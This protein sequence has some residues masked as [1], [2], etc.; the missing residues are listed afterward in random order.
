MTALAGIWNIDGR[1]DAST[2]CRRMLAAQSLYGPH[3]TRQWDDGMI[4]LG[5]NLFR[6]LPEDKHDRQPVEAA[7]G[8]FTIVADLRLDN[9]DELC[10]ALG[11]DGQAAHWL[12]DA[13]LL[14]RAWERWQT[15]TFERLLG[16]YAVAVWDAEQRALLLGR[17]PL[18]GRPLHYHRG[19]GFVAFASMPKGL[20]AL[21]R[22]PYAPDKVRIAEQ[23]ILMPEQGPR[24]FF[25]GVCRVEPGEMVR[26]T[27]DG[28]TRHPHW[29]PTPQS[30]GNWSGGDMVEAMR[31]HIDEAVRVRLRG[32][33]DR[34]GAHLSS[35]FDSNAVASTAARLLAPSGGQVVAF[36]AVPRTGYDGPVPAGRIGDEGP[37]AAT[38]AS[39]YPNMEHVLMPTAHGTPLDG[40]DRD[41]MLFDQPMLNLCNQRWWTTISAEA[42]RRGLSVMLTGQFG[43][44]TLSY[45]GLEVLPWLARHGR[46]IALTRTIHRLIKDKAISFPGA[47]RATLGPWIPD[48]LWHRLHRLRGRTSLSLD[49]YSAVNPAQIRALDLMNVAGERA[50]DTDYR[51]RSDPFETRMWVLRR[52]DVGNWQKGVLAGWHIDQR[53]PTGDRRLVEFCLSLP[54]TAWTHGGL[55][56]LAKQVLADR[57]SPA[58]LDERRGG[59]QAADWHE[60]MTAAQTQLRDDIERFDAVPAAAEALDLA[61]MRALAK[62]W[63]QNDWDRE[64]TVFA[65]RLALLRGMAAGHFLRKASGSNG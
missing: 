24:S 13:A 56:S 7:G 47:M 54:P 63:P 12:A 36:T 62:T 21:A 18:G 8:R 49:T 19:A 28:E 55:R 6:L 3:D 40:L 53:D 65:Y 48:G 37:L 10:A 52:V 39:L 14:A 15:D 50:L 20:H 57:V 64:S 2:D 43:N 33:G 29:N 27:R 16:D 23:L 25:E 34:V 60:G 44:M 42:Q 35:G 59:L 17:D 11:I 45:A 30:I 4:A 1:P 5:R 58:V 26:L 38:T 61:R 31:H 22:V 51:P 9:R 41:F 46:L 32:A